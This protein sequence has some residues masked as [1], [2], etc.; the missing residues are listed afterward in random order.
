MNRKSLLFGAL[1]ATLL[2]FAAFSLSAQPPDSR[3]GDPSTREWDHS[4]RFERIAEFLELSTDQAEQ[5]MAIVDEQQSRGNLRR[6]EIADL[7]AQFDELAD[8]DP[9]DFDQLGRVALEIHHEIEAVRRE[10]D[11]IKVDL[12]LLLTPEQ[13]ERFQELHASRESPGAGQGGPRRQARPSKTD[14]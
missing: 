9:P 5:W 10:R 14:E 2:G 7:R 8:Q 11:Q 1:V 3:L 6:V 12:E 4:K 13:V